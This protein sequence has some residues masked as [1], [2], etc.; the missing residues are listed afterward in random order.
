MI[1]C[2]LL[3]C[4]YTIMSFA[5]SDSFTSSGACTFYF[6]I[7]VWSRHLENIFFFSHLQCEGA[8]Y[9]T[10]KH[11]ASCKYSLLGKEMF[12]RSSFCKFLKIMN[13][14]EF[15]QILHLMSLSDFFFY[16]V[17]VVNYIE[18]LDGVWIPDINPYLLH[19]NLFMCWLWFAKFLFSF[20]A[21]MFIGDSGLWSL[22]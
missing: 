9:F 10:I 20:V 15:Y 21:A 19:I 14:F 12:F 11:V 1:W 13:G 8:Q 16:S 5:D 6:F 3:D 2:F 7:A 22:L 17:N 4:L 18:F